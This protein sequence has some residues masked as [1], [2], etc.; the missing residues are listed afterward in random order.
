MAAPTAPTAPA[1]TEPA[2]TLTCGSCGAL[3]LPEELAE[4]LAVRVDGALVCPLCVDSLP[5]K[6]Q[7]RINQMRA[8]RGLDATTYRVELARRPRLQ[9]FSFT[10]AMNINGH[11]RKLAL[12]GFFEAPVLHLGKPAPPATAATR[13][14]TSRRPAYLAIAAGLVLVA[15]ATAA[16]ALSGPRARP[17]TQEPPGPPTARSEPPRPAKSRI[18]YAVDPL[19]GWLQAQHDAECPDFVRQDLTRD[20]QRQRQARLDDADEALGAGHLDD[21]DHVLAALPALPE[22]VVFAALRARETEVR[23]RLGKARQPV[24]VRHDPPPPGPAQAPTPPAAPLPTAVPAPA[25]VRPPIAV[26]VPP[27][28]TVPA[29]LPPP[30]PPTHAPAPLVSVPDNDAVAWKASFLTVLPTD[31]KPR[32]LALDGSETVPGHWPGD[33]EPFYKSPRVSSR[34]RQGMYLDLGGVTGKDGGVVVLLH[35]NRF[36]RKQLVATLSDRS[37]HVAKLP[38]FAFPANDWTAFPIPIPTLAGF[39]ATRLNILAIEDDDAHLDLPEDA[40]FVVGKVVTVSGR[41]PAVRDLGLRPAALVADDNRIRNLQRLTD[42]LMRAA[43]RPAKGLD[44]A[45]IRLLAAGDLGTEWRTAA[46]SRLAA[47]FPGKPTHIADQ[48]LIFT[49]AW[50]DSLF[51][52]AAPVLDP[53]RDHVVVLV[54]TGAELTLQKTVPL[55]IERFWKHRLAAC[56]AR[57]VLPVVVLGPTRVTEEQRPDA[58]KL[59]SGVTDLVT[60]T[61]NGGVPIIDLRPAGADGDGDKLAEQMLADGYR[62]LVYALR[63]IGAAR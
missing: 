32:L 55:T 39:D 52:G 14:R 5:G 34:K 33:A 10:T 8:V 37:G 51:T 61:L 41:Q 48:E 35:P 1:A 36:D 6:A 45:R 16:V 3:I 4:G 9:L 50:L 21:A 56:I 31:A 49:H 28:A 63:R 58:E 11:R 26:V 57:G 7:V 44:P 46:N 19:Q 22:D 20:V 18:D 40:G 42:S 29:P 24:A 2:P 54:T 38:P 15:G 53:A 17:A 27:P 43:K 60:D 30:A 62:E 25:P 47:L 23:A 59:W 12:N 13:P